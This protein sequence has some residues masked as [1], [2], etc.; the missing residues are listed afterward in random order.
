M[1]VFELFEKC[2]SFVKMEALFSQQ[3]ADFLYLDRNA[4]FNELCKMRDEGLI[5]FEKTD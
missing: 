1:D 5:E 3:L 2:L 4:M